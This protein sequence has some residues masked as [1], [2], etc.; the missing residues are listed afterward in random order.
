MSTN[1]VRY[2]ATALAAATALLT[3]RATDYY[4][5]GENASDG[6]DGSSAAPFATID[7]AVITARNANDVIHVAEGQYETCNQ[8][9]LDW[10]ASEHSDNNDKIVW[11]GP[12]LVCK[13]LGEGQ[14]RDRVVLK[15]RGQYRT[16]RM[17][18]NAWVEN[19]TIVG[20]GTFKADLGGSIEISGG[21]LT[22]CIVR[23]GTSRAKGNV[24]GGNIYVNNVN[25][26][27]DDCEIIGG[28]ATNRGGNVYLD[29]G[30]VRNCIIRDGICTNNVGGNVYQYQGIISNCVISGG[31]ADKDG[32]N[33]RMNG[34]G[35]MVDCVITDG[36]IIST[37][38][39]KKGANVYMD[40][41]SKMS[42][43]HL[44]G[45]V[46]AS[47]DGGSLCVYSAEVVVEDCI[48]DGSSCGGVLLGS[49]ASF[50]NCSIVANQK[51]GVWA[52]SGAKNT[53]FYN[54]V[55][56]GNKKSNSSNGDWNGDMPTIKD[57]AVFEHCAV[58]KSESRFSK[59]PYS[60]I[61]LLDGDE[62]FVDYANGMYSPALGSA[63]VDAGCKDPRQDKS[64]TDLHG[65]ARVNG[66]AVDIGCYELKRVCVNENTTGAVEPY[67]T[68]ET[69][70]ATIQEALAVTD[71]TVIQVYPGTYTTTSQMT[72]SNPVLIRGV[73]SGSDEVIVK[74]TSTAT[75]SNP[76]CRVFELNN[77]EV[78]IENLVLENGQVYNQNGGNLRIAAGVAS[79][80]VI[81]GGLV[82]PNPNVNVDNTLA[83]GAGVE[84]SGKGVL[85]HCVVTNNVVNGT[86]K[87]SN[88]AYAGGAVFVPYG[89]APKI[90]NCLVAFNTYAPTVSSVAG[91]AG[92]RCGGSNETAVFENVTVV[93]NVVNG[94]I[95]PN[96]A[97]MY[98]TSWS[99]TVRNCVFA[100]NYVTGT[101][102]LSAAYFQNQG[103]M[104][105]RNCAM[106]VVD[107]HYTSNIVQG[108]PDDFFK[109]FAN[110]DFRP[111]TGGKLYNKGATPS[112]STSV[113]LLGN[114]RAFGRTID[115][116]CY[117]SQVRP[118]VIMIFY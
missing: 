9:Y 79:K 19:V 112:I 49:A 92:I 17:A 106:D 110:G 116:G 93:S 55:I 117:E 36:K 95:S 103:H 2:L 81:R 87:D 104:N 98:C 1:T 51:Y 46:H 101:D 100:G 6:N 3:V 52:W 82:F 39:D 90:S 102:S 50:Y 12:K 8:T 25:A 80:C 37:S 24:S 58:T 43:C 13:L 56:Y 14:S 48:I 20:E 57:S 38:G 71:A 73:P 118:G 108:T 84:V 34:S 69:A 54:T 16:L 85:T 76:Y 113:D 107:T 77:S 115:I 63:L 47:Y 114:P 7:K 111:R 66:D 64:T 65:H 28:C 30:I 4:V 109:D 11:W 27:V 26:I 61:V 105:V 29:R 60:S 45:G 70:L 53:H 88:Y 89:A 59:T 40:S 10:D 44:R 15:S 86:A 74:N 67:D 75:G 31:V 96:S 5:G 35:I 32:G 42:R 83:S 22:N 72:I 21:V 41:T 78:K 94:T 33:V 18:E 99:T 68:R 23:G 91:S 62:S 97:G